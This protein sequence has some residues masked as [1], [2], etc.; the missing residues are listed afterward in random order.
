MT[1]NRLIN[2]CASIVLLGMVYLLGVDV[3]RDAAVQ[4]HHQHPAC[5]TNLKP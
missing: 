5:H 1:S 2:R 3:G 4:A